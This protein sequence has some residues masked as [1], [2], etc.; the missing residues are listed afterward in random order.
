MDIILNPRKVTK[1]FALIFILVTLAHIA[2]KSTSF[3]VGNR[4]VVG[5]FDLI[6]LFDLDKEKNIPTFCSTIAL[7]FCS[8]LLAII[9][10]AR[11][12]IGEGY[13]FWLGL[14]IIFLFIS[15]DEFAAI[16]C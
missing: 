3:L 12:K 1:F 13:F 10:L 15:I 11:K 9:A 6:S 4:H 14:S 16:H 7:V 8:A 5:L 2:V